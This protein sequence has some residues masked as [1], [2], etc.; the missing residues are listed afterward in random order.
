MKPHLF[1]SG[2]FLLV[3]RF[4]ITI[5][6]SM[7]E[8]IKKQILVAIGELNVPLGH[9]LSRSKASAASSAA[10]LLRNRLLREY[11]RAVQNIDAKHQEQENNVG[12]EGRLSQNDAKDCSRNEFLF[13]TEL[14]VLEKLALPLLLA[15]G[16]KFRETL[17]PQ[18][19]KLIIALL[20]PIPLNSY[21]E[22]KQR[23]ALF[24]LRMNCGTDDFISFLV[25]VVAPIAEK[26]VSK[27]ME[28]EDVV[29]LEAVLKIFSLILSTSSENITGCF[30]RNHGVEMLMVII[31]QNF[32]KTQESNSEMGKINNYEKEGDERSISP[33]GSE[34]LDELVIEGNNNKLLNE[35]EMKV[36]KLFESE[37]QLWKWNKLI[38]ACICFV[39][40]TAPGEDVAQLSLMLQQSNSSIC[41]AGS[42]RNNEMLEASLK[43]RARWRNIAKSKHG[44]MAS[45]AL[46]VRKGYKNEADKNNENRTIAVGATSALLG[47]HRKD[48]LEGIEALDGR[49]RGRFVKGMFQENTPRCTLHI[50]TQLELAQQYKSFFVFGFEPLH[51]MIWEKM[52][53]IVASIQESVNEYCEVRDSERNSDGGEIAAV[54][55]DNET[56]NLLSTVMHYISICTTFL[57]FM[58]ELL[59][60]MHVDSLPT[61]GEYFQSLWQRLSNII[62]LN[63]LTLAISVLQLHLKCRKIGLQSNIF[64]VV[65]FI[66]EILLAIYALAERDI[67]SNPSVRTAALTLG[68][69]ILGREDIVQSFFSVLTSNV[70]ASSR[71][72]VPV[73]HAREL[74]LLAFSIFQLAEQCS[75]SGTLFVAKTAP[76]KVA[77]S[78]LSESLLQFGEVDSEKRSSSEAPSHFS[79]QST[80]TTMSDKEVSLSSLFQRMSSPKNIGFIVVTLRH[81]RTNDADVNLALV[82]L[83]NSMVQNIHS[84]VFFSIHFLFPMRDILLHGKDSHPPLYRLCDNLIYD[85]FNPRHA[86]QLDWLRGAPEKNEFN[87]GQKSSLSFEVSLRCSRSLFALSSV[88]Y[89]ILEEKG[90]AHKIGSTLV[91]LELNTQSEEEEEKDNDANDGKRRKIDSQE[92]L[93]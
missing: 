59:R 24:K 86:H 90:M 33:S 22:V 77:E 55:I 79:E 49:K 1:Y 17:L 46:F 20:L 84:G 39:L 73:D 93:Q 69:T 35:Y 7:S 30:C 66:S 48:I 28:K 3:F 13:L 81:W 16:L 88:D 8:L 34:D 87:E 21:E 43:E 74:T 4:K 40:S 85:F 32:A 41:N 12:E 70:I 52:Q 19:L 10:K 75:F 89:A 44:A 51:C 2:S 36:N 25:Q 11:N 45:N 27:N 72:R 14:Q 68:C 83:M 53:S 58:R 6:N 31:N 47:L 15:H 38:L 18:V 62:S 67:T 56:H 29:L 61:T 9:S 63:H 26:R 64:S 82:Y 80:A 42:L 60:L 54:H 57:Q 5:L 76:K 50:Q 71:F 65:K 92:T 91:P 78:N 37:A 23:D